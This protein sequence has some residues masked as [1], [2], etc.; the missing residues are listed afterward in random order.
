MQDVTEAVKQD[1][2]DIENINCISALL[3]KTAMYCFIDFSV[4]L[5]N[6]HYLSE[7]QL[8]SLYLITEGQIPRSLLRK[9][10]IFL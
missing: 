7:S 2:A 1:Y 5:N 10:I 4:F 9:R 6:R 8:M 3:I